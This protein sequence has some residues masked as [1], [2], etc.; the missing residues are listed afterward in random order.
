[1]FQAL[2]ND[3]LRDMLYRLVLVYLDDILVFPFNS[4]ACPPRR[5]VEALVGRSEHLFLV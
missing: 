1:V 3:V 5:E 2:V 4:R